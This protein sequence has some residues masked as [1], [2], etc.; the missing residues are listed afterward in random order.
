MVSNIQH[1]WDDIKVFVAVA[2]H[3]SIHKAALELKLNYT[4][5]MRRLKTLEACWNVLLIEKT[6]S[7]YQI[8]QKAKEYIG[9]AEALEAKH[10]E[11]FNLATNQNDKLIG[12]VSITTTNTLY[13]AFVA[14]ELEKFK[15]ACPQI[16]I[17]VDL[18]LENKDLANNLADLAIR[19]TNSPPEHLAGKKLTD[20]EF[21]VFTEKS[22]QKQTDLKMP[23]IAWSKDP[24]PAF[25]ASQLYQDFEITMTFNDFNS[26][27]DAVKKGLG[28]ALLPSLLVEKNVS[29]ELLRQQLENPVPASQLWLLFRPEH[30]DIKRIKCL[31]DFLVKS[32]SR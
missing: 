8:T 6:Q 3:N 29:D 32:L 5:V 24:N 28:A 11:L 20:I 19:M 30:R 22:L 21:A 13:Q 26:I 31:K 14:D 17:S 18:S 27:L 15:H 4:T 12:N 1:S 2:R 23:L 10:Q 16:T 25:W 9:P 7:G